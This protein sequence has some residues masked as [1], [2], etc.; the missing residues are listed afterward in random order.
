MPRVE[1]FIGKFYIDYSS[2]LS[3]TS[4]NEKF[5]SKHNSLFNLNHDIL[6][7]MM[8]NTSIMEER[9]KHINILMK[10]I[11]EIYSQIV[12]FKDRDCGP[13]CQENH[14]KTSLYLAIS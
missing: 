9:M 13:K 14:H 8:T 6:S 10:G 11:E 1:V 7:V 4:T 12:Q 2:K 5:L 3:W